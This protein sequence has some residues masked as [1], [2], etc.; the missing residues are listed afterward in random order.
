VSSLSASVAPFHIAFIGAPFV[1][2]SPQTRSYAKFKIISAPVQDRQL[3]IA[4]F[5]RVSPRVSAGARRVWRK[6]R[7]SR[8]SKIGIIEQPSP[9][10]ITSS[11]HSEGGSRGPALA[12]LLVA[13]TAHYSAPP[14]GVVDPPRIR[15]EKINQIFRLH[16]ESVL[17]HT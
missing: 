9:R 13:R 17:L 1:Q 7:A 8:D 15:F 10:R 12:S 3:T 4:D 5:V 11:G 16:C 6:R 14:D 2:F